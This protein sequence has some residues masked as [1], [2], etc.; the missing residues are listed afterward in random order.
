MFA[1]IYIYV[2][3]SF[4]CITVDILNW[5]QVVVTVQR[6]EVKKKNNVTKLYLFML[7]MSACIL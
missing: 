7:I 3:R 4:V 2:L 1:Y 6:Y 5:H